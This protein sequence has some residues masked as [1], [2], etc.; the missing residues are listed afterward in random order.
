[1]ATASSQ[2]KGPFQ[3]DSSD[4]VTSQ[5]YL[6]MLQYSPNS[7][8][9]SVPPPLSSL[10]LVTMKNSQK[11]LISWKSDKLPPHILCSVPE[12]NLISGIS[13]PRHPSQKA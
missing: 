8:E 3:N 11:A 9:M 2:K 5:N 12:V 13:F 10:I 1:M 7:N 6:S 4:K